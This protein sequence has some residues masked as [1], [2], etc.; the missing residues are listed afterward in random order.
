MENNMTFPANMPLHQE[1]P[2]APEKWGE[3]KKDH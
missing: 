3:R 2:A 1:I